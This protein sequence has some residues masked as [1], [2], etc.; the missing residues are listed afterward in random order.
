M[1]LPFIFRGLT[2]G[3]DSWHTEL[4]KQMAL[5][6]GDIRPPVIAGDTAASHDEYRKFRHLVR[7]I[8]TTNLDISCM[9]H[10]VEDLPKDVGKAKPGIERISPISW[11]DSQRRL[12]YPLR[13]GMDGDTYGSRA[14]QEVKSREGF[15]FPAHFMKYGAAA[16]YSATQLP[17]QYHWR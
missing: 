15:S 16:T 9:E 13:A 1:D 6:L 14:L 5:D 2:I 8:Y 4:V 3:G 11:S 17:T 10:L 7:N 12:N